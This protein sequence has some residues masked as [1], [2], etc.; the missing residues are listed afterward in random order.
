MT[1]LVR[2]N[3][4]SGAQMTIEHDT[5]DAARDALVD[6]LLESALTLWAIGETITP[7]PGP[8]NP[9]AVSARYKR[10]QDYMDRGDRF[11]H[12]AARLLATTE[13]SYVIAG[14]QGRKWALI[15]VPAS[16]EVSTYGGLTDE[17]WHEMPMAGQDNL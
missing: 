9:R 2:Y 12:H 8:F 17:E 5:R 7:L 11:I 1:W 6:Q 15:E 10:R 13:D 14:K 3:S 16:P 4:A